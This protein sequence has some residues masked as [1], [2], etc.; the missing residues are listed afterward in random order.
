MTAV[1]LRLRERLD[2]FASGFPTTK[3]GVEMK[4][5]EGLFTEDEAELFVKLSPLPETPQDVAKRLD[6][7]PEETATLLEGMAQKGLVFR[8]RK[9]DI[10]KYS[11]VPFV[12]GIFDF[13]INLMDRSFAR[14]MTDYF[15]E[16]LSR[17]IMGHDTP[18]MRAVPIN[19]QLMVQWPVAPY[20]DAVDIINHREVIAVAPCVC[21][22]RTGLLGESCGR[23]IE[24]CF[25]FG[26]FARYY[27]DNGMARFIDQQEALKIIQDNDEAGLVLQPHNSLEPTGM[28]CCCGDCCE[29]LGS[30][31]K[32]PVPA[33]AVKSNY[34]ATVDAEE[35]AGCEIC[36]DRC[37]MEAITIEDDQASVDLNRCI[38]CG[39][40]V[41]T[42]STGAMRLIK[43]P[44]NEQYLPPQSY[45]EMM[46]RLA[47]ERNKNV[48]PKP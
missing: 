29:L 31:K 35:C 11:A 47:A 34:R 43:K 20:E 3:S 5:L 40:C 21:R 12:P 4:L 41:T 16:K 18:F 28:C 42:C 19:R 48:F 15:D 33:A 39:L 23:P 17:T 27:V 8:L 2:D 25:F 38:G 45:A 10:T 30:L 24:T 44:E 32:Q 46:M 7:D 37:Q 13:Q 26:A 6:A 14:D 36:L 1:Y 9:G 22:T